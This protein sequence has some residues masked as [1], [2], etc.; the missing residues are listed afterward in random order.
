MTGKRCECGGVMKETERVDL[1]DD[2]V[3]LAHEN[4]VNVEIISTNTPEGVQF[5]RS[6]YG[7]GATLRYK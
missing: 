5:L 1:I 3:E 4:G 6:F 2:L 7:I